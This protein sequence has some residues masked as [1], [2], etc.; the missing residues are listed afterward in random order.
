M[1]T[2]LIELDGD[3]AAL[4]CQ[5]FSPTLS[6][7]DNRGYLS[8]VKVTEKPTTQSIITMN[9]KRCLAKCCLKQ[10]ISWMVRE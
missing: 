3:R 2:F 8:S 5:R 7:I 6:A 9:A 1:K 10:I 4:S